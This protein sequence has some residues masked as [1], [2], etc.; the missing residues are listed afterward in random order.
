M[1]GAAVYEDGEFSILSEF[2]L[3]SFIFLPSLQKSVLK[4]IRKLYVYT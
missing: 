2:H 3:A 4:N 1:F